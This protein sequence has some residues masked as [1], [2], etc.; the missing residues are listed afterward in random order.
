MNKIN[1]NLE[2]ENIIKKLDTDNPPRLLLHSCCGPCSSSVLER[3]GMYFK[4]TVLYYNPNIDTKNEFYT[5]VVEQRSVIERLPSKN[6]IELIVIDYDSSEYFDKIKGYEHERE[7]GYRCKLCFDLRIEEAAKFAKEKGFDYFTTTLSVSPY[8]NSQLLNK[9]GEEMAKKYGINYLYSD[10]K[11]KNG[12]RRS[13]ELSKEYNLYRQD[14][15]GCIF[16][17]LQS[18]EDRKKLG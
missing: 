10:F 15:C 11:K 18:M 12:Y 9:I 6:K 3:L 13:I 4:I 5:R 1:Y 17:K 16:S 7:G 8:K 2:M 14:Y